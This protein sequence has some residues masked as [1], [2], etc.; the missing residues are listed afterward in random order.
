MAPSSDDYCCTPNLFIP[1]AARCGTTSLHAILRQHPDIYAPAFKEPGFFNWPFQAV[2]N[3]LAYFEMYRSPRLYRVDAS[4]NYLAN[5]RV[6]PILRGLFPQSK[7]LIT[8]RNPQQRAYSLYALMRRYGSEDQPTFYEALRAETLRSSSADFYMNCAWG[9]PRN[10]LYCR[11]SMYD[12][13]IAT[14]LKAFSRKQVY[15]ISLAELAKNPIETTKEM[16]KFLELPTEP[17]NTF[18]FKALNRIERSDLDQRS[19]DLMEEVFQGLT[20][21]TDA[22]VGRALDWS[23]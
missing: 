19:I 11:S 2:R 4:V 5:D 12:E 1:G 14:Y 10:Y 16:L 8:V 9:D 17:V 7:V 18:A 21:R 23:L 6:A 13:Q 15:I 3:P 22:L 20:H